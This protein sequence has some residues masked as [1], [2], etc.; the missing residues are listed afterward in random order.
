MKRRFF[1]VFMILL[2][3]TASACWSEGS[4]RRKESPDILETVKPEKNNEEGDNYSRIT[5]TRMESENLSLL[6]GMENLNHNFVKYGANIYY[7]KYHKDSFELGGVNQNYSAIK[8]AAKEMMCIWP[9]GTREELFTDRGKGAFYILQNRIYM[10][11][12][13]DY[14]SNIYSVDMKGNDYRE[15]GRGYIRAAD[16]DKNIL[17]LELAESAKNAFPDE[18]HLYILDAA[19]QEIRI[20]KEGINNSCRFLAYEKG[21]IYFQADIADRQLKD[22]NGSRNTRKLCS[23]L[24]DGSDEKI[25]AQ[26]SDAEGYKSDIQKIQIVDGII[27]FSYGGYVGSA[28]AYQGGRIASVRLDGTDFQI[29]AEGY[30]EG[31][32]V[33]NRFYV[34]KTEEDIY[35]HYNR[36][37]EMM[38]IDMAAKKM[39]SKDEI[40]SSDMP[41]QSGEGPGVLFTGNPQDYGYG[42]YDSVYV[43]PDH[44][45]N[46]VKIADSIEDRIAHSNNSEQIDITNIKNLAYI[47]GYLYFTYEMSAFDSTYD[48]GWREGFRRIKTEC[49]RLKTDDNSLELLYSY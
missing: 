49:Y 17:I 48:A 47:D 27:F 28:G 1:L 22:G 45:G 13:D 42:K 41:Y 29:L 5:N 20:L 35:I 9:D 24:P 33:S 37:F 23:I 2:L 39:S 40:Y 25:L 26:V 38:G 44:K 14:A 7:R 18:F 30:S 16:E 12:N 46:I 15:Y 21:R 8:G 4:N 36:L 6:D 10:V 31:D 32:Y 3:L 19:S 43:I 34:Q 11:E